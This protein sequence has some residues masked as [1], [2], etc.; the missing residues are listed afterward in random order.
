MNRDTNFDVEDFCT[1]IEEIKINIKRLFEIEGS[2]SEKRQ[3]HRKFA[4]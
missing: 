2:L 1:E 3:E 4:K